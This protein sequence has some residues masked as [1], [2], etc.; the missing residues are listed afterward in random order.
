[1]ATLVRDGRMGLFC[2][3]TAATAGVNASTATE[4]ESFAVPPADF[5]AISFRL[6]IIQESGVREPADQRRRAAPLISVS[7]D[8]TVSSRVCLSEKPTPVQRRAYA[9]SCQTHVLLWT[10]LVP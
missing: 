3:Q 5:R 7:V 2:W 4:N 10:L 8:P 6:C 1:M 9:P